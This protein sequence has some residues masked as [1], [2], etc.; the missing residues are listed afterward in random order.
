MLS[1]AQ[2]M[3]CKRKGG[4]QM[5]LKDYVPAWALESDRDE[6]ADEAKLKNQLMMLARASKKKTNGQS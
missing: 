5:R 2:A 1:F 6:K 3:G 4:G